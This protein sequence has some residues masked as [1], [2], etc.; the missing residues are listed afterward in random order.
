MGDLCKALLMALSHRAISYAA[1][2]NSEIIFLVVDVWQIHGDLKGKF[3]T[4]FFS[5]Y[6]Y[7]YIAEAVLICKAVATNFTLQRAEGSFS[8]ELKNMRNTVDDCFFDSVDPSYFY[9]VRTEEKLVSCNRPYYL[10]S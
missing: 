2:I 3:K 8:D 4:I 7:Y 10:I 1:F 6:L 5:I 9:A